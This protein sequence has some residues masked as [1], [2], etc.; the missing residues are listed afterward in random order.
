MSVSF[1]SFIKLTLND[2]VKIIF[3]VDNALLLLNRNYFTTI[4]ALLFKFKLHL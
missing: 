1:L 3:S 2:L 4:L